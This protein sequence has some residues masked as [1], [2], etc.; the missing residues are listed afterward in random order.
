MSTHI[1]HLAIAGLFAAVILLGTWKYFAYA[2][3]LAHDQKV[4]AEATLKEDLDKAKVQAD[5]T[6]ADNDALQ[7]QLNALAA[8]NAALQ[9]DLASLRAQLANQRQADNA[10]APDALSLRWSDLLGTPGQVQPNAGGFNVTLAAGHGTVSQLEEI[11]VLRKEKAGIEHDSAKKD[12][13]LTQAK[14]ALGST[15][16]ELATCK[17][18][19]LDSDALCKVIMAEAKA[20][21]RKRNIVISVLAAIG[22][23]LLRSKI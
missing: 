7:G 10:M 9:R 4:L 14:K 3:N 23:F 8:S 15:A 21:D 20:K 19:V 16:D 1:K 22:G 17:K 11:P 5:A 18:T 12:D 2:G 6:K 13:A